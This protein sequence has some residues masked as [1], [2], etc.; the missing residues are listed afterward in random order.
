MNIDVHVQA[1]LPLIRSRARRF[2]F[3]RDRDSN[4]DDVEDLV[5]L[6]ISEMVAGHATY[7]HKGTETLLG[8]VHPSVDRK[9][10]D[11][12]NYRRS[13]KTVAT[14]SSVMEEEADDYENEWE[15]LVARLEAETDVPPQALAILSTYAERGSDDKAAEALGMSEATYKRRKVEALQEVRAALGV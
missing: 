4:V 3:A 7:N 9:W 5:T 8:Y 13:V 15:A 1:E 12:R 11:R 10:D 2:L 6:A 14:G